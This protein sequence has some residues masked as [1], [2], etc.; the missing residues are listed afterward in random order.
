MDPQSQVDPNQV[1][2]IEIKTLME[3]LKSEHPPRIL[4]CREPYEWRQ[5]RI[6]GEV[7]Y[8]PMNDIPSRL[9][10]LDRTEELVVVCAH[11]HR[12]YAVAGYLIENGFA[13]RSLEGG[14]FEWYFQHGE[15]ESGE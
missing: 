7:I 13:A 4:D 11:G 1:P 14:I 12:S 2:E 8:I 6:P 15:V 10:E 5:M 9:D 3:A